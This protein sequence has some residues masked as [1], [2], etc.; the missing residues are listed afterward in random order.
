MEINLSSCSHQLLNFQNGLSTLA[1]TMA[2]RPMTATSKCSK[3]P[4]DPPPLL[5]V[6]ESSSLWPWTD[7]LPEPC[8]VSA[9]GRVIF[10]NVPVCFRVFLM[11]QP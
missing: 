2:H 10:L 6:E 1:P 5:S 3:A 4:P 9:S 7:L 8:H 11:T